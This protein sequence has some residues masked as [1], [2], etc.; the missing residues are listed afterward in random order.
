MSKQ[1]S[2]IN[3]QRILLL[4]CGALAKDILWLVNENGLHHIDVKC[5]PAKLHH[6]PSVI[7]EA[8]RLKIREN[9]DKYEK[10]FVV[11]GDCGTA[12]ALDRV[13]EEEGAIE[14]IPG[15]HCFSFYWGNE[16]FAQSS[17]D[18]ITTF[19]LTDFFC[20]FFETF[21]WEAYGLERHESM[22]DFVFGNYE[23]L[24]YVPQQKDESLEQKAKEIAQRLGLEFECRSSSLG[25]LETSVLSLVDS[26]TN[27]FNYKTNIGHYPEYLN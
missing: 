6:T 13:L 10:I 8:V 4:A 15:P 23:K 14:R 12:G 2:D 20:R 27:N 7:P 24:V 11:Y 22:I 1:L 26:E 16:D 18:E 19:Y 17:A 5:L 3:V 9:K 21:I 25:D